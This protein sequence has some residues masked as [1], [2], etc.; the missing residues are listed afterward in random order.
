[1][2]SCRSLLLLFAAVL[3][4]VYGQTGSPNFVVS[5]NFSDG[6]L[7]ALTDGTLISF[8]AVDVNTTATAVITVGNAGNAAGLF[9]SA[10]V[11][12]NGFQV[13]G[14]PLMPAT[15]AAGQG[16][17]FGIAFTP[18][19]TGSFTGSFQIELS[20][21]TISGSL[22]GSTAPPILA[23]SYVDPRTNSVIALSNGATVQFPDT[24]AGTAST[25]TFQVPNTGTGTGEI[26]SVTL[27][28]NFGG[29]LE[30]LNLTPMPIAVPP[31]FQ[32]RF[33]LRFTSPEPQSFAT[34]LSLNLNGQTV[35]VNV[36]GRATG[37]QYK[38]TYSPDAVSV[39][40]GGTITLPDTQVGQTA[41]ISVTILNA[42][43][44]NGQINGISASGQAFTVADLP[45][46]PLTLRPNETQQFTVNFSPTEPGALTGRLAIGGELI[47]LA[48]KS[49]GPKLIYTYTN[50][51]I[52][53]TISEAGTVFLPAAAVGTTQKVDFAVQNAG[54]GAATLSSVNTSSAGNI[55]VLQGVPA[56]PLNLNPGDSVVFSIVF[57]PNGTGA[58]T[59]VLRV[60]TST[61][62]LSGTGIQPA[63]LPAYQLTTSAANPQPGEQPVVGL[64]LSSPYPYAVQGTVVLSFLSEVFTDDPAV[65]FASGGRTVKFTIAANSTQAIFNGVSAAMPLQTGTT[66]GTIV[67]TPSFALEGGFDL[68]PVSPVALTMRIPR[69]A[70]RLLTGTI[71][72]ETLSGFAVTLTG[73]STSRSL[74]QLDIQFTPKSGENFATTHLTIDVASASVAWFQGAPS[75]QSGGAFQIAIPFTLQNGST[76][77][78][79]VH[80]LES[81]A[82]TATNETGSSTALLIPVL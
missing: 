23:L 10:V 58:L 15:L 21:R 37:P 3:S 16:L 4:P 74:R 36:A 46:F 42:G 61:F 45:L 7:R 41:S 25:V 76:S 44:A 2:K 64:T 70:P 47:L 48:G 60:N 11:S 9:T 19:K 29:V 39:L 66:A 26:S 73:Y 78:D 24:P 13:T 31:S 71:T 12:G 81:L 53:T 18:P 50:S 5:Y 57:A 32:F 68:T 67:L 35:T 63:T 79:L 65:Q 34:T 59:A 33:G 80:R 52:P 38:Y 1:M 54:T 20:G 8:P 28:D 30:L 51:S 40:S 69:S 62:A 77:D 27:G 82:V 6:N 22:M 17:R 49:I 55:F 56:L 72:N 43:S 14:L 75:Q